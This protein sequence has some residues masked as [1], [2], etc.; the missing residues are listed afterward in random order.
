MFFNLVVRFSAYIVWP[1]AFEQSQTAP[2]YAVKTIFKKEKFI[3]RSTSS[4]L[5]KP[6]DYSN[7]NRFEPAIPSK[8]RY[9]ISD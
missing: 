8:S 2:T 4:V 3:F 9:F 7:L 6:A 5:K 1:S